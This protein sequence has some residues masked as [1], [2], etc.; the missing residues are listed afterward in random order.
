LRR[1]IE[2]VR[3]LMDHH[4][5]IGDRTGEAKCASELSRLH[6]ELDAELGDRYPTVEDLHR[7]PYTLQVIKE[8]LRL[9]PPAPFYVRDAVAAD[10]LCGYAI[11]A[12]GAVAPERSAYEVRDRR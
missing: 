9:Y 1:E 2:S 12:G 4:H 5:D 3:E 11:P 6:E 8:V 7:L 10:S